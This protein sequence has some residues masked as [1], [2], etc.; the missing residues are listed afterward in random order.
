MKELLGKGFIPAS[1][2]DKLV[3]KKYGILIAD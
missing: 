3:I 1:E 2:I